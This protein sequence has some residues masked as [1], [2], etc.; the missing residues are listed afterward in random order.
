MPNDVV[1]LGRGIDDLAGDAADAADA[2]KITH[3]GPMPNRCWENGRRVG[4]LLPQNVM[5]VSLFL[6][7]L[8][9][10]A[11]SNAGGLTLTRYAN[12]ACAGDGKATVVS[13]LEGEL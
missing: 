6:A 5:G 11:A 9:L 4:F 2:S 3:V 7:S 8:G 10:I 13:K 12:T 1:T